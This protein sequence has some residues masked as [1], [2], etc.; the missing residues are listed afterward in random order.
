MNGTL[1][2]VSEDIPIIVG[3]EDDTT[4][5]FK[6]NILPSPASS[7]E[8]DNFVVDVERALRE[9]SIVEAKSKET[10]KH[11]VKRLDLN[12]SANELLRL[13]KERY[14]GLTLRSQLMNGTLL[15]VR[16][17]IPLIGG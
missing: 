12:I 6:A 2:L 17:D 14:D 3:D 11:V 9:K 4:A 8:D 7:I 5:K 15:L 1:L 10:L 13:N 16:E